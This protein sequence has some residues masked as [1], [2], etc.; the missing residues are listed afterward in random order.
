[1]E[2]QNPFP[3]DMQ[4]DLDA[5]STSGSEPPAL[6]TFPGSVYA[7]LPEFLKKVVAPCLTDE[8]RDIMLMGALVS[9]SSCL[10]KVYG[11]YDRK[12][13]Y[14]NLFLFITAK[15]SAGKGMLV[16]CK[17]LVLP[18]HQELL[19]RYQTM[20]TQYEA[21]MMEYNLVKMKDFNLEKPVKPPEKMLFLPANN[22]A[23]GVFQLLAD[24]DGRGL[25]FENEGDT[26]SHAFKTDYGNYSDGFRKAF[27][28]EAISYYR[29]TDR[30]FVEIDEPCLSAVLSGT[31]KQIATLIPNAENGLFS[32]F[33]FYYMNLRIQWMDV[34]DDSDENGLKGYYNALGQKLLPLYQALEANP[35]IKFCVSPEQ[36]AQ[37]NVFFSQLQDKYV[38]I[39]GLDYM[40]TIRRLGLIAYRMAMIFTTLRI[41]ETGDFSQKQVCRDEDFQ[42]ALSM[43]RVLVRHASHVYSELPVEVTPL[44][45]QNKKEQ[46]LDKLPGKFNRKDY[47]Q[48]A[49][50][51]T[52]PPRTAEDYISTFCKKG[53]I[54]NEKYGSYINLTI[55]ENNSDSPD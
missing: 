3:S 2:K 19:K 7:D 50:S 30:E 29:R 10:P 14:P 8:E 9:L 24:N 41:L 38:M 48:L 16:L 27:H 1:M 21:E 6:P 52:I 35:A 26:L 25:I 39:K 20:K 49:A 22:S 46:F 36:H 51:L 44:G 53:L 23:T 40:A 28:H 4:H 32:R 47:L 33:I 45:K 34:L 55:P 37:F 11:I 17:Q 12:R 18:V 13:V 31:P 54:L 42:A 15:A 5:V 43:V